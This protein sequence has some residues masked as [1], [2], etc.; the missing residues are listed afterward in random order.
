MATFN[1]KDTLTQKR[2]ANPMK[3]YLWYVLLPRLDDMS[4][5]STPS[6][7][8]TSSSIVSSVADSF[9]S[10]ATDFA[11]S[12]G[13]TDLS[14]K[15]MDIH[16]K[17]SSRIVN[18][19]IPFISIDTEKVTSQ[20]SYW[21][22]ARTNDIGNIAF[23]LYEYED[24]LSL[25]YI[26]TWQNLMINDTYGTYNPPA[27]YK[28]RVKFFRLNSSRDEIVVHTYHGYFI[29]G[30]ADIS[31]DYETNDIVKYAVNLTGDSVLH[32]SIPV[33]TLLGSRTA[34]NILKQVL[35]VD[36]VL[37]TL[38]NSLEGEI[39]AKAGKNVPFF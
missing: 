30:V 12:V 16:R 5:E 3:S 11:R 13:V 7:S 38:Q 22:Y 36:S 27:M 17:I 20:N 26:T 34:D 18:I 31:N 8:S 1:I 4:S 24:G 10:A 6:T 25:E 35:S 28:K 15:D 19:S 37:P 23:E 2:Q 39:T 21:Y 14:A 33:S 29:S 9:T 32:E